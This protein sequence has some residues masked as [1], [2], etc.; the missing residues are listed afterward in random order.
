M[1]PPERRRRH[2]Q[3]YYARQIEAEAE[4]QGLTFEEYGVYKG[5]V[6]SAVKPIN[7]AGGLLFLSILI[8]LIMA[9]V[10]VLMVKLFVDG[11][12]EINWVQIVFT[13]VV[14]LWLVPT[15]WFLYFKERKASRLRKQNG[16]TIELPTRRNTPRD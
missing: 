5:D 16:K 3:G 14:G 8:T 15:A 11:T 2:R 6:G 1:T 9:V 10:G 13:I 7:S 12:E 4:R